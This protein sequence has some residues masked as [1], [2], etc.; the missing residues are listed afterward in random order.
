MP[1]AQRPIVL[2]RVHVAVLRG[3]MLRRT[4]VVIARLSRPARPPPIGGDRRPVGVLLVH[5]RRSAPAGPWAL[6]GHGWVGWAAVASMPHSPN[7]IYTVSYRS[8]YRKLGTY[9]YLRVVMIILW[10]EAP[11][12][13]QAACESG[14]EGVRTVRHLV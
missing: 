2:L 6:S 11:A 10:C 13:R 4:P 14:S 3:V 8:S 7:S 9:P 5:R 12:G 1:A